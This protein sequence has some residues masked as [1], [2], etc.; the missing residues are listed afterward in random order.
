MYI[1]SLTFSDEASMPT[2]CGRRLGLLAFGCFFLVTSDWN[3]RDPTTERWTWMCLNR[4]P[5]PL[6]EVIEKILCARSQ[7][8]TG[9]HVFRRILLVSNDDSGTSIES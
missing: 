4:G 5:M 1:G 3:Y 7:G 6:F 2:P 9:R 8:L